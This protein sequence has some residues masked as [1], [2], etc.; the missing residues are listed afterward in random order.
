MTI[1][2][3]VSACIKFNVV[4]YMNL[5]AKVYSNILFTLII[6]Q[7][8]SLAFSL[9]MFHTLTFN[10]FEW[11]A[12]LAVTIYTSLSQ[13]TQNITAYSRYPCIYMFVHYEIFSYSYEVQKRGSMPQLVTYKTRQKH[14][15]FSSNRHCRM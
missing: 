8:N 11:R 14:L 1:Y 6:R 10:L 15:T 3:E 13:V 7:M 5:L 9:D 12:H 2:L 4:K